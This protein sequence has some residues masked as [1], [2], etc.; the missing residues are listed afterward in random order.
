MSR[1]D[2][3][4]E[5]QDKFAFHQTHAMNDGAMSFSHRTRCV[6]L[7]RENTERESSMRAMFDCISTRS[8]EQRPV[9][10]CITE[11]YMQSI[12]VVRATLRNVA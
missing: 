7:R 2:F 9:V 10:R 11:R 3:T 8:V 1:F 5:T 12:G 4:R 6:W